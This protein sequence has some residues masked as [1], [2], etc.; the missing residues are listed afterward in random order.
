MEKNIPSR[1][2][3][4]RKPS[5]QRCWDGARCAWFAIHGSRF[6]INTRV[7]S[8]RYR[9]TNLEPLVLQY[10]LDSSILTTGWHFCLE[11]NA[12]G[13]ISN[14]FALGVLHFFCF[15][16]QTILDLFTY[17]FYAIQT[18]ISHYDSRKGA[19]NRNWDNSPPIRRP[20]KTPDRF[21]DI[22]EVADKRPVKTEGAILSRIWRT[23]L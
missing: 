4:N 21:C 17:D 5:T 13:A 14:N 7:R 11:H 12:E 8:K 23:A 1:H 10:S 2:S 19:N 20:E 3:S 6:V 15:A 9:E 16:S 22:T 18:T